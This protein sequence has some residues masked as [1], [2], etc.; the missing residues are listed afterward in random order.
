MIYNSMNMRESLDIVEARLNKE[1]FK[2]TYDS[3]GEYGDFYEDIGS[4]D[5]YYFKI[6]F[7]D[8]DFDYMSALRKASDKFL[9]FD[10]L[11]RVEK[12]EKVSHF[13]GSLFEWFDVYQLR[14][15][16]LF[17]KNAYCEANKKKFL[18]KKLIKLIKSKSVKIYD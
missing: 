9:E 6:T 7:V 17:N 8:K 15:Q 10:K 13:D 4:Y 5:I 14:I 12:P 3:Q 11:Y 16:A 2:F 18:S 1:R